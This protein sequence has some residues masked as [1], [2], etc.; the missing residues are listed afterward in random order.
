M[1]PSALISRVGRLRSGRSPLTG[2]WAQRTGEVKRWVPRPAAGPGV[3]SAPTRDLAAR[4]VGRSR[5]G[6]HPRGLGA[7]IGV[8]WGRGFRLAPCAALA[9]GPRRARAA[10]THLRDVAWG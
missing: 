1:A 8:G 3:E 4:G 7:E 10:E 5:L 9:H 2:G 6:G